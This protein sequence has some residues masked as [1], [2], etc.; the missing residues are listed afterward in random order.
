MYPVIQKYL[1]IE[2]WC[3]VSPFIMLTST[4]LISLN[5]I[6]LWPAQKWT[7][8]ECTLPFFA[9]IQWWFVEVISEKEL[10][11]GVNHCVHMHWETIC[12]YSNWNKSEKKYVTVL[13]V[14]KALIKFINH[15]WDESIHQRIRLLIFRN[16]H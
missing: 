10:L 5:N 16:R 4:W 3:M 15:K 11:T 6:H 9:R 13:S 8:D 1:L 7:S 14:L 12:S 2:I